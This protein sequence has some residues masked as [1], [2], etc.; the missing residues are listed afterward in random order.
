MA[1][2]VETGETLEEAVHREVL[3]ETGIRINN[4][5]YFA[6]QP[7]P[8]PSGVMVGYNA[9]YVEG[10]YICNGA[11]FVKVVGSRKTICLICP[12]SFLLPEG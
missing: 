10:E 11:N 1:G 12:R 4:L 3:E 9:D 5:C 6:S 7:W 8:Y 2:F